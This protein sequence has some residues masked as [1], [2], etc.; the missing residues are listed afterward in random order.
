MVVDVHN[1][2]YIL[3]NKKENRSENMS[4]DK[5]TDKETTPSTPSISKRLKRS[6]SDSSAMNESGT[7]S[8]TNK[9]S[10]VGNSTLSAVSISQIFSSNG[11]SNRL[12]HSITTSTSQPHSMSNKRKLAIKSNN[13]RPWSAEEEEA[14]MISA[15]QELESVQIEREGSRM[16]DRDVKKPSSS[17]MSSTSSCSRS[18]SSSENSDEDW[19]LIDWEAVSQSLVNRTAVECLKKY[20]KLKKNEY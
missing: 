19:D 14:L 20:L 18:N 10:G 13:P 1:H 6:A 4:M 12:D 16:D 15:L 11:N 5:P 9:I 2:T 17:N 7:D 8:T 3:C